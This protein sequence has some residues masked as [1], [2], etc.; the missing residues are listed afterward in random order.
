MAQNRIGYVD[1]KSE[2]VHFYVQS[3]T[4]ISVSETGIIGSPIAFDVMV[5]NEGSAMDISTGIFIAPKSGTYLF[6]FSGV[7]DP[8]VPPVL[9]VVFYV[10]GKKSGSTLVAL[11][12]DGN[13]ISGQQATMTLPSIWHL[14]VGDEVKLSISP[15]TG[16][17]YSDVKDGIYT[18]FTGILL[19]EDIFRP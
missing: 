14:S 8:S 13:A 16:V 10:N 7:N 9:S 18:H 6:D 17:L 19:E 15:T 12:D 4:S 5:L 1:V 11:A 2:P 3:S